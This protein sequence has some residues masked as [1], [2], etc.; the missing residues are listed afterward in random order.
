MAMA[1]AEAEYL[2]DHLL[3]I[4]ELMVVYWSVVSLSAYRIII[5]FLQYGFEYCEKAVD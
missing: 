3:C 2:V 1:H 5:Q 4:L